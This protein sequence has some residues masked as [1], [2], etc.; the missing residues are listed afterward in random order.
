MQKLD[1]LN[2]D[3]FVEQLLRLMENS[4]CNFVKEFINPQMI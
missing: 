2:R 3:A 4:E 1:I